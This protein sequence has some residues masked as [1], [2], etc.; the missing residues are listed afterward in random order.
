MLVFMRVCGYRM[1]F[2]KGLEMAVVSFPHRFV[3]CSGC[4]KYLLAVVCDDGSLTY[5]YHHH[6]AFEI[7]ARQAEFLYPVP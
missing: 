5:P 6:P 1:L 4:D 7:A 2:L 3:C